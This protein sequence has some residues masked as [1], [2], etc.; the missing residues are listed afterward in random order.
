MLGPRLPQIGL[1]FVSWHRTP[2]SLSGGWAFNQNIVHLN[3]SMQIFDE[4]VSGQPL[5]RNHSESIDSWTK[6]NLEVPMA[7]DPKVH[8]P[9]GLEGQKV[10]F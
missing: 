5:I 7:S 4:H 8:A 3:Y 6:D 10:K 9:C 2:G 1:S